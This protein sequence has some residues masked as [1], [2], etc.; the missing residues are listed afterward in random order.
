MYTTQLA[1]GLGLIQETR[2]LLELWQPGL[3]G[4][5]L[6]QRALVSGM[7]PNVSAYRLRNIVVRCFAPRYLVN[8]GAP[9][10]WLKKL[11]STLK[12]SELD[13]LFFLYTCRA[14]LILADFVRDT[15]WRLYAAGAQVVRTDDAKSFIRRAIDDGKT[16]SRWAE[17]QIERVG[18][19]LTG[20]CADYGL[21][22]DRTSA[23]R[24][25]TSYRIEE[26]AAAYLA[27]DLHFAGHGD[28][29]L[30]AHPD[31]RLFG[32]SR[33]DVRDELKR[34]S[35]K[36]HII[37]QSAGDIMHIGWKHKSMEGFLD[38]LA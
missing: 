21:L 26:K 7:F 30:S 27:Y 32:L 14:N 19:Y 18:R 5:E 25:I 13:Q 24:L 29:S 10:C 28:N 3:G 36:G 17:G 12:P 20:C 11:S 37:L 6:Y 31:W 22:G 1:M 34:L 4:G 8:G 33:D 2:Q 15:Y 23:G 16:P 38:V 35:L 9:A